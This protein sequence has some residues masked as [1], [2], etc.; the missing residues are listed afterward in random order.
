MQQIDRIALSDFEEKEV[1]KPD[2]AYN[3]P[4]SPENK[5]V[6]EKFMRTHPGWNL[7]GLE[8]L[9]THKDE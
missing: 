6:I 3:Y 8:S 5:E 9:A 2:D 7:F 1:Q 4:V